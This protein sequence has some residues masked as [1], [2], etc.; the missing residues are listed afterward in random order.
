VC[1]DGVVMMRRGCR[2]RR[3]DVQVHRDAC[4]RQGL[5]GRRNYSQERE[6]ERESCGLRMCLEKRCIQKVKSNNYD[7]IICHRRVDAA[8]VKLH[9]DDLT[10]NEI[11][12]ELDLRRNQNYAVAR[13]GS[14]VTNAH[15]RLQKT[16]RGS[17][18]V[19]SGLDVGMIITITN[20]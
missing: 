18:H 1:H 16:K 17:S 6:R 7:V 15:D 12:V 14:D 2:R 10:E 5:G 3:H 20:G 8:A 11:R 19:L 4:K 13:S 9:G